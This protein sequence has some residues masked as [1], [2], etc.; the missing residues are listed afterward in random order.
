MTCLNRYFMK[1]MSRLSRVCSCVLFMGLWT[2]VAQAATVT[3]AWDR[4]ADPSVT[5]YTLYWGNLPGSH[6]SSLNVGNLTQAQVGGLTDGMPYYFVVRAYNSSGMLS[7]ES[8]EVSR[9]VGIPFAIRGDFNG[10]FSADVGVFRPTTGAWYIAGQGGITWGGYG[11]IPVMGDYDG[12]GRMDI[13]V[14]R[15]STGAWYIKNSS[16]AGAAYTWGGG[17]DISGAWR[18]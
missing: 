14:F 8:V 13:A 4:S 5:G 17:G 2:G 16:N 15:P 1:P 11:D 9:R 10:D 12:D 6:P 18:L 3:L 7:S